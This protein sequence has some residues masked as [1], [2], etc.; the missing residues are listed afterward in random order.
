M[1]F[2]RAHDPSPGRKKRR[3]AAP[4]VSHFGRRVPL[5][6]LSLCLSLWV[7]PVTSSTIITDESMTL[8]SANGDPVRVLEWAANLIRMAREDRLLL[9]ES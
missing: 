5:A 9:G 2:N 6:C 8:S 4:H 1:S 3:R 7:R